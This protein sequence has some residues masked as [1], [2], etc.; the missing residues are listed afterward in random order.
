MEDSR[1]AGSN[2]RS[3]PCKERHEGPL[4]L[5]ASESNQARD[6][7]TSKRRTFVQHPKDARSKRLPVAVSRSLCAA[8]VECL[9]T[10]LPSTWQNLVRQGGCSMTLPAQSDP[11]QG[12]TIP[13]P[14]RRL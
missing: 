6:S 7:T 5:T 10:R 11:W 2:R 13:N 9:T 3:H 14:S 4:F 8:S 1:P 12:K